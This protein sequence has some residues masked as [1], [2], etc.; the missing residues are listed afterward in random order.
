VA[1]EKKEPQRWLGRYEVASED[2]HPDLDARAAVYEFRHGLPRDTAE[3]QAHASY[4]KE[5]AYDAASH[6]LLGLRAAAAAGEDGAAEKHGNAYA[7]ALQHT[8]HE[9]T[10]PVPKEVLDR[11]RADRPK[12]Y[13]FRSHPAD[14]LFEPVDSEA[15]K[16]DETLRG[17]LE[18]LEQLKTATAAKT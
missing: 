1:N 9:P 6:H 7:A 5:K 18:K 13:N 17:F 10:G 4:S 8:G 3:R 15:D 14:S 11:I 12:V 16:E 2:D